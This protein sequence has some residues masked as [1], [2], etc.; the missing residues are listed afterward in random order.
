MVFMHPHLSLTN[1]DTGFSLSNACPTNQTRSIRDSLALAKH[2]TGGASSYASFLVQPEFSI[3][4]A[5]VPEIEDYLAKNEWPRNTII[6]SGIEPVSMDNF[7]Q[8]LA[9]SDNPP[10]AKKLSGQAAKFANFCCI[11]IKDQSGKLL[12]FVQPKLRPSA[13]EQAA[14][15]MYEGDFVL[16]FQAEL[17]SFLC[18]L[19]FDAIAEEAFGSLASRLIEGVS[20]LATKGQSVNLDLLF[21]PQHNEY[22]EHPEFLR[23]AQTIL[24]KAGPKVRTDTCAVVYLNSASNSSGRSR[25]TFGR[26]SIYYRVGVWRPVPDAGPISIVP[27]TFALESP[28]GVEKWLV[29]ARFR[30]DG[31]CVHHFDYVIPSL[32]GGSAGSTS[33]PLADACCHAIASDGSVGKGVS[34]SA[35]QKVFFDWVV[36]KVDPLDARLASPSGEINS[37]VADMYNSLREELS[38]ISLERIA[39]LLD[40]LFVAFEP[41]I[42]GPRINPDAWQKEPVNWYGEPHGQ[43]LLE[44]VSVAV[45][46]G[47]IDKISVNPAVP[48]HSGKMGGVFFA[49]VDGEG[50]RKWADVLRA[51]FQL[52]RSL[53]MVET[54][55][56]SNLVVLTR[57]ISGGTNTGDAEEITPENYGLTALDESS[58]P[59]GLQAKPEDI[60]STK[61]RWYWHEITSLRR[62]L[63]HTTK[64]EAEN[65][66]RGRL[67][68]VTNT[69]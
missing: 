53:P 15:S 9:K 11:W 45:V 26:S 57:L 34:V 7:A 55:G 13:P 31:P 38:G 19:C 8:L 54:I 33:Y 28:K 14:Q 43:A 41:P 64:V 60:L 6:I 30:E 66:L 27:F 48:S 10:E 1:S 62:A 36:R 22:A 5:M 20:Q 46:L 63:D 50:M 69:N 4:W 58:L 44:M 47:L 32:A 25:H 23:F 12:R 37:F 2:G 68:P 21:V 56:K 67:A 29:R 49:I 65:F 52:A 18:L 3:P 61:T 35:L 40:I 59:T 16:L 39:Q 17:L 51:Y 24:T 42:K